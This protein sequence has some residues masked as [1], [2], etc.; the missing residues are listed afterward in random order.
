MGSPCPRPIP[1]PWWKLLRPFVDA[2]SEECGP[3]NRGSCLI[4]GSEMSYK[5]VLMTRADCI[6]NLLSEKNYEDIGSHL[7]YLETVDMTVDCLQETDIARAVFRILKNCPSVVLKNKAKHLLS[8]WKTLYKHHYNQCIQIKPVLPDNAK[9]DSD[10]LNVVLADANTSGKLNQHEILGPASSK[11]CLLSENHPQDTG[12]NVQKDNAIQPALQEHVSSVSETSP[13]QVH[14]TAMRCKCIELLYEALVDSTSNASEKHRKIAEEVEQHIFVLYAKND[15]KYKNCV[16]SKVSNLKNPKNAHL[17]HNLLL[18]TLNPKTFAEMST[19]E[20]A[21]DELKK[22][23]ASYTE[24][25]VLEH[26]LP[27][28]ISGTHTDKI[29]CRRCEKF[30]CT[31]TAIARGALFLPGWVRNANPDEQMMT[32]VIC[33]ECGEQWYHSRWIC[34]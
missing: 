34:L 18:G 11:S 32:Y 25:S 6:E 29:K 23:R 13:F 21:H 33:N 24:S 15:R 16:R 28:S 7:A 17:K 27:Q 4:P 1:P 26:Q 8:K 3:P 19:M 20:M 14:T 31:V 5:K 30:D 22:L 9:V 10:P 2:T 12:S